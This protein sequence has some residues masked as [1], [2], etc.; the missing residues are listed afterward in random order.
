MMPPATSLFHVYEGTVSWRDYI[1]AYEVEP[2]RAGWATGRVALDL[3]K[4]SGGLDR[5]NADFNL[6]MGDLVWRIEMRRE[7]LNSLLE[8]VRLAEFEREA[9]AY[10]IRAERAYENGWYEEALADFLEAEK[11][12]YPDFAVLRS[13]ASIYL[14]HLIELPK[15]LDY[16]V[17]TSKYARP[18]DTRQAA[19]AHFFAGIVCALMQ[20][21][22]EGQWHL[23]QAVELNPRLFEARY[24]NAGLA[25]LLGDAETVVAGLEH[26]I[27]GDPRYFER[28]AD[29][30]LFNIVRPRVRE[31]LDKLMKPVR[32]KIDEVRREIR[33]REGYVVAEPE[34]HKVDGLFRDIEHRVSEVKTYKGGIEF[35]EALTQIRR[36]LSDVYHLF[37]KHREIDVKDYVRSVAFSPDGR[38]VAAGFLNGGI[39]VWDVYTGMTVLSIEAH[40]ASVNSVAFSP[41][42]CWLVSA[43]RDKTIKLWDSLTG[44]EVLT[45]MGHPAEVRA[46]SF[47]P[48]GEWLASGSHDRTVRVWRAATGQQVQVLGQHKASVTSV[49]FS[50]NGALIASGG[51][52]KTVKLW[53]VETGREALVLRGH[54]Q[55]VEALA[56]SPDGTLLASG[57]GDRRIKI[58]DMA[59]CE[60]QTLQGGTS[61]VTCLSFSPDGGLLAAGFLGKTV[62]IWKLAEG[63]V[64]KSLRFTDIS[65]NPVAFS[66]EGQWLIFGSRD[67]QLW[68]RAILTEEEY[69]EVREGE[70]RALLLERL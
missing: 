26:A 42:S 6:Q 48:N 22:E 39:K 34:Q 1:R 14:Y 60:I 8:E 25:A 17:K 69:A 68:L 2:G 38:L 24:Q 37:Y 54:A 64:I 70:E 44:A 29:D 49:L 15:A 41:D 21:L 20:N 5:L 52:D 32:Q 45:L 58:W 50:P 67:L 57:G 3:E 31:L 28:A 11:R 59:G 66:P 40:L 63:E 61:V 53:E 18:S 33:L 56:F 47:S 10:R 7:T 23:G 36:Q 35:V 4:L 65:Y 51:M 16:F 9:R 12:N 55:G 19:E 43:G 62:K 27:N 30:P 13:I 46:V